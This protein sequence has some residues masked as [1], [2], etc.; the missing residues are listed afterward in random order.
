VT[1]RPAGCDVAQKDLDRLEKWANKDIVKF[2]TGKC[3]V[4]PLGRN[5]LRHQN[6]LGL[7]GWKAA[8]QKR[9]W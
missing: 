8:W 1:D 7:A 5:N 2:N 3:H 6:R 4:L 9:T